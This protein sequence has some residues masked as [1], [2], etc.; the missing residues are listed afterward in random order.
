MDAFTNPRPNTYM[1]GTG[2][3]I[4]H[5]GQ[6]IP[7]VAVA[8]S[9]FPLIVAGY[10]IAIQL[11][12]VAVWHLVANAVLA[13]FPLSDHVNILG[14]VSFW[15]SAEPFTA[16]ANSLRFLAILIRG[17]RDPQTSWRRHWL[18]AIIVCTVSLGIAVVSL[19]TGIVLPEHL[20]VASVAPVAPDAVYWPYLPEISN[21]TV[22]DILT[23]NRPSVLR[24]LGGAE[25]AELHSQLPAVHIERVAVPWSNQTHPQD[26]IDYRY[27]VT[28][29]D[30]GLQTHAD[31]VIRFRGSCRTTYDWLRRGKSGLDEYVPWGDPSMGMR[32]PVASDQSPI[33]SLDFFAFIHPDINKGDQFVNRSFGFA[34]ATSQ[35]GSFSAS[36][37]PWF[38]TEPAPK[39]L[40]L[41]A[42]Y[43]VKSGRP[44]L[45]CWETTHVCLQGL[46]WD[47]S[48]SGSTAD[49]AGPA[50][51]LPNGLARVISS[52]FS[53]PMSVSIG[54][55]A[56]VTV[57]KSYTGSMSGTMVDARAA[58]LYGE[59]ERL[60]LASYLRSRLI[61]RDIA[62]ADRPP[63]VP[64]DMNI[65]SGELREGSASFTL[66]TPDAVALR[67][68]L[69]I[70]V[71]VLAAVVW[72][73][74]GILSVA[75][76]WSEGRWGLAQRV[77][78]LSA[79]QLFRMLHE[80]Q[81][82]SHNKWC[83]KTGWLPL[84]PVL[85]GSGEISIEQ[86]QLRFSVNGQELP[87]TKEDACGDTA[88]TQ[89]LL[90]E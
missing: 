8:S 9:A 44:A 4:A 51:P 82:T 66:G 56:G 20:R 21:S 73:A 65:R 90:N 22:P 6:L 32:F 42:T 87:R 89:R 34:V 69:L 70:A 3:S 17:P 71:P 67:T 62:V 41:G 58:S 29:D 61:F 30:L 36:T 11:L 15:N 57:L 80:V 46:C 77:A 54:L 31:L 2:F 84:P 24:A 45:S 79:P 18:P 47:A 81:T 88:S 59:M 43:I 75:T 83:K 72:L 19:A 5:E 37:D 1:L 68:D 49:G 64:N 28:A 86:G 50:R 48:F 25:A 26:Q 76:C 60:I 13:F 38:Y 16:A 12:F 27:E 63:G 85:E 52:R 74:V 39:V 10:V 33:Y 23:M 55:A 35:I 14:A 40:N 78:V 7:A 53:M